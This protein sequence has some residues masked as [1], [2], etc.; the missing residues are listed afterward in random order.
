M[1]AAAASPAVSHK[2]H[3]HASFCRQEG[4]YATSK[5]IELRL[6]QLIANSSSDSSKDVVEELQATLSSF[7]VRAAAAQH[8][9]VRRM[10]LLGTKLTHSCVVTFL[11]A[12]RVQ[13]AGEHQAD[14]QQV[15]SSGS[16]PLLLCG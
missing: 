12:G 16:P 15:R 6:A 4:I 13:A 10:C 7:Q 1:P 9:H 8:T 2:A 14:D 3:Q 11:A 5:A